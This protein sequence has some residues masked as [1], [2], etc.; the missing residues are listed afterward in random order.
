MF[1]KHLPLYAYSRALEMVLISVSIL[2][3]QFSTS[4]ISLEEKHHVCYFSLL[5]HDTNSIYMA[6]TGKLKHDDHKFPFL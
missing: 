2:L 4:P 6:Q 3:A 5:Y 1:F